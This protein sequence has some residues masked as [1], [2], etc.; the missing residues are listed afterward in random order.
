[1]PASAVDAGDR[2]SAFKSDSGIVDDAS[3]GFRPGRSAIALGSESVLLLVEAK[4]EWVPACKPDELPAGSDHA[5]DMFGKTPF[6]GHAPAPGVPSRR[7]LAERP[8]RIL[9]TVLVQ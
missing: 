3:P 6:P 8:D 1:V 5:S 9:A 4:R 7:D 2:A